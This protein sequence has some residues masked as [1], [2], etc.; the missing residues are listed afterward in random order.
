VRLSML[1]GLRCVAAQVDVNLPEEDLRQRY[2]AFPGVGA[3]LEVML[4]AGQMLYVPASWFHEVTSF[5]CG[6]GSMHAAVNFWFHPPDRLGATADSQ[7]A[8]SARSAAQARATAQ[9]G[10][11]RPYS[12]DFWPCM[13]NARVARHGWDAALAVPLSYAG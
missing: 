6:T 13:W 5:G 4:E 8:A 1:V 9:D 12:S 3:A 7:Q 11:Q 2:P 10:V